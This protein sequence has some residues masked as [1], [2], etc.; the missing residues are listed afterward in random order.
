MLDYDGQSVFQSC[1]K[2]AAVVR[3]RETHVQWFSTDFTFLFS[4]DKKYYSQETNIN[5]MDTEPDELNSIYTR[6]LHPGY[7]YV[8]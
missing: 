3:E 4:N 1:I 7:G 5:S 6:V 2:K 8:L